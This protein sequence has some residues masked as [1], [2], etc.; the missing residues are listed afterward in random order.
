MFIY[1]I[2][3]F[4]LVTLLYPILFKICLLDRKMNLSDF[5]VKW[6]FHCRKEFVSAP[7]GYRL[8]NMNL[9]IQSGRKSSRAAL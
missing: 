9:K 2:T 4:L 3:I 5:Y 8:L 1:H 7:N 6:K